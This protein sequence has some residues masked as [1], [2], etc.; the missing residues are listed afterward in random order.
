M[1]K[2]AK[3]ALAGAAGLALAGTAAAASKDVHTMDVPLTDG[4]VAHIQYYGD[5][6]PKVTIAPRP[7]AA[8]SFGWAPMAMP[9]IGHLDQVIEQMN[10]RTE[11]MMR[12]VQKMS[13]NAPGSP[14]ANVASYGTMPQGAN[15]VTVVSYSNGGKTCTR[16]TR[17]TSQGQGKTPKVVSNVSGDCGSAAAPSA[18]SSA[19]AGPIN[20]T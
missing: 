14:I 8:G 2:F 3:L 11:A 16:T 20:H 17:V 18:K 9:N 13:R 6:A 5:V 19:A 1:R 4:S 7:F 15:S 10:R 12:Q